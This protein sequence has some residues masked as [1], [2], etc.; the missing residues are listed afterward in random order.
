MDLKSEFLSWLRRRGLHGATRG[1]YCE[2]KRGYACK[3]MKNLR[4]LKH[5]QMTNQKKR[6]KNEK[7]SYLVMF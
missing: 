7:R 5:V 4:G 3:L 1:F 6:K 2:R